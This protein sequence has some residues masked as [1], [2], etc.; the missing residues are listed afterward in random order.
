MIVKR[1][2]LTGGPSSGKTTVLERIKKVYSTIGYKVILVEETATSLINNEIKPFGEESVDLIDFQEL[3]LTFQLDKEKIYDRAIE[4]MGE[5]NYMIVYDR[6]TIDNSAYVNPSE[7]KTVLSRVNRTKNFLELMNKY[8]LVIN[9]V[10]NSE[11]YTTENNKARSEKVD[12]AIKLGE[13]T[14]K[15]WLGHPKL[16]IVLPKQEMEDKIKEVL[17]IINECLK[18]SNVI[19]QEKYLVD[20]NQSNLDYI[21]RNGRASKITQNYLMSND[22]IEKRIRKIELNGSE[23]YYFTVYKK[24]EN[25]NKIIL[26]DKEIDKNL[27]ENLLEFKEENTQTIEKTRIYFNY[28]GEYF[29]LD[30]FDNNNELGILEINISENEKVEIPDFLNV[31]ENVTNNEKYHN[32]KI[33]STKSKSLELK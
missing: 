33:A 14:L 4:L 29:Y 31:I 28:K 10:G 7:F 19:R 3:V 2:V 13:I 8:D 25:G 1:I 22:N 26:S 27:Y 6:G 21:L 24:Q 23:I 18:E 17:N 9:L 5:G 12:E 11:Y 15:S 20:L 32:K 16:K 30:I